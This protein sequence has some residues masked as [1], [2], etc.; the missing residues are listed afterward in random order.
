MLTKEHCSPSRAKTSRRTARGTAPE[1]P[2]SFW[3]VDLEGAELEEPGFVA[4]ESCWSRAFDDSVEVV[5]TSF[6]ELP[7]DGGDD[8]EA[9]G[10]AC[11]ADADGI[12]ADADVAGAAAGADDEA[13]EPDEADVPAARVRLVFP[14]RSRSS[15]SSRTVN[16]APMMVS[17]LP[18]RWR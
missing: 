14:R 6:V 16:A 4:G 1:R 15:F 18:S 2:R 7:R 12:D 8:K 11:A 10:N 13:D 9:E 5:D 3:R 17:K